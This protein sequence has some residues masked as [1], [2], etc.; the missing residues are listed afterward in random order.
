MRHGPCKTLAAVMQHT[1]THLPPA[2]LSF[3]PMENA[4][5]YLSATQ[6]RAGVVFPHLTAIVSPRTVYNGAPLG[7]SHCLSIQ[8]MKQEM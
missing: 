7:A 4:I 5:W 1:D 6:A 3:P 2:T 8:N